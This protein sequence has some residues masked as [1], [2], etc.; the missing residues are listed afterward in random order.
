[1]NLQVL[2]SAM[3]QENYQILEKMNIQSDAIIIN[4]CD[5]TE[6][7]EFQHLGNSIKFFS[8]AERGVGLSRNNALMRTTADICLFADEDVT[9]KDNYKEEVLEAFERLPEAD[10]ILFNVVS[11]NPNRPSYNITN[12]TRI[13][14]YN[15]LKYGAVRIAVRTKKLKESNVYFSLLFGGGAK[16]GSGEDSMFLI[17]C[18]KKGMKIYTN[19]T[20]IGYV[21][22]EESSWFQGYTDKFFKDKGALF[23]CLSKRFARIL[24]FQFIVRQRK[25]FSKNLNLVQAYKLMTKGIKEIREREQGA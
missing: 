9:Y 7:E 14:W 15:C 4:Q 2:V 18:I 23:A 1:M 11:K 19:P 22:Q 24:C 20:V 10:L 6:L 17:D 21:S 16:Y 25:L 12:Q 13:R 5:K 3:Y 8:L